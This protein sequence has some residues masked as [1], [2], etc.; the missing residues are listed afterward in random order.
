MNHHLPR[1]QVPGRATTNRANPADSPLVAWVAGMSVGDRIHIKRRLAER[2]LHLEADPHFARRVDREESARAAALFLE[3]ACEHR[4]APAEVES[5][6]EHAAHDATAALDK[7]DGPARN[8]PAQLPGRNASSRGEPTPASRH[9]GAGRSN[10][11][12]G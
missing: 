8:L 10:S 11:R 1:H 3:Y 5:L 7:L 6:L 9:A 12:R 4:L 2:T